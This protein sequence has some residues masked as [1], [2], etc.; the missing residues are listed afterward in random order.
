MA[1]VLLKD[2]LSATTASCGR[3][4]TMKN[5]TET[6]IEFHGY[7]IKYRSDGRFTVPKDM[8]WEEQSAFVK[9]LAKK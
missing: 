8:P 1:A 5:L 4:I 2:L 7:K 9:S 6:V 3:V